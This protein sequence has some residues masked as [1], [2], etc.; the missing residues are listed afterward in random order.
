MRV[1]II[2]TA[3]L[4]FGLTDAVGQPSLPRTVDLDAPDALETLRQTNPT[5]FT[6]IQTILA[7]VVLRPDAE[8]PR[9]LR[10]NFN[11][12][13]VS[14]RPIL[15]TSHPPKRRLSLTLDDTRYMAVITLTKVT[16]T[17]VPL[18]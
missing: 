8:V 18:K 3:L 15:L 5:H 9:W 6:A 1:T 12:R 7:E 17:I 11:A 2:A 14:Y 10:V 4:L 13:G 16:G